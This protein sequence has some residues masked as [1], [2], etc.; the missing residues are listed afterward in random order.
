MAM[1]STPDKGKQYICLAAAADP[2]GYGLDSHYRL[3]SVQD[4]DNTD[5]EFEPRSESL[6]TSGNMF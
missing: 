2:K 5:L 1:L 4:S 6:V 3:S